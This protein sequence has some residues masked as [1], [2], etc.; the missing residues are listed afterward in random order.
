MATP[1]IIN[2]GALPND[3]Q[4]DPLRTAFEKINNNFAE[5][6]STGAFTYLGFTSGTAAN[7]V[8]FETDASLF[9]QGVFQINSYVEDT[10]NSQNITISSA[11]NNSADSVK[12]SAYG[13]TTFGTHVVTGY[14]MDISEGNVRILVNPNINATMQHFI[15]AQITFNQTVPGVEIALDGYIDT[16]LATE[17]DTP[18][19]TEQPA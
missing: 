15:S 13:T 17:N 11:I 18:L 8:I 2:I 6:F 16:V 9:T 3:G 19:T 14:D 4:G 12:F 1:E 5:I 7:Q 10:A